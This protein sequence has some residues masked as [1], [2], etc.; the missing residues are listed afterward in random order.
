MWKRIHSNRDPAATVFSE[1]WREFSE[2]FEKAAGIISSLVRRF[3]KFAFSAMVILILVSFLLTFTV[4]R[5]PDTANKSLVKTVAPPL[6][7]GFDKILRAGAQLK[8]TIRL[9][10]IVDSISAKK[11][12]SLTDSVGLYMAL[13]SLQRIHPILK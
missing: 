7:D 8:E 9:K 5:H 4:F 6:A 3:P 13:D 2:Y 12:L 11:E 10:R 1:I